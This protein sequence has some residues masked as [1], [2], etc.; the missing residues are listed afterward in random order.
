MRK[1]LGSPDLNWLA[2]M[3]RRDINDLNLKTLLP[4]LDTVIKVR[5]KP[6][7]PVTGEVLKGARTVYTIRGAAYHK[8]GSDRLKFLYCRLSKVNTVAKFLITNF[9]DRIFPM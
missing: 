2:V 4:L 6:V 3:R 5:P 1:H 8:L 7:D 9:P